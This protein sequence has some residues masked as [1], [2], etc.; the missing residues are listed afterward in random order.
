MSARKYANAKARGG[1]LPPW[2]EILDWGLSIAVAAEGNNW[3]IE[4]RMRR[5][6]EVFQRR[7][8]RAQA[9]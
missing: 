3:D 5:V 1:L 6:G 7:D 2:L 8:V 4:R 9:R